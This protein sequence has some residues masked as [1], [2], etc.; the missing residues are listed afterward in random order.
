[1]LLKFFFNLLSFFLERVIDMQPIITPHGGIVAF[2]VNSFSY[3]PSKNIKT[4]F[5]HQHNYCTVHIHIKYI[6]VLR[7]KHVYA[8]GAFILIWF[9][10]RKLPDCHFTSF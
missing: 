8:T 1:M 9:A 6:I 5:L 4:H 2:F 7:L 10:I 3:K